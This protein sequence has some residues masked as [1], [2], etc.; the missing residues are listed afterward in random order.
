MKNVLQVLL[1]LGFL[2]LVSC[3]S[4]RESRIVGSEVT[5]SSDGTTMKG[6]LAYDAAKGGKQPGVLVVHE[7]WGL[8]DYARRRARMLAELGYTALAVDMYGAGKQAT[9]PADASKFASEVMQ[10]IETTK[11]RFLAALELLRRQESVD[12]SQVAAIG[13]CFGGGVVLHMAR[14]GVDLKGVASFHGNLATQRPAQPGVVKAR[15]L[16]CNG[17]DDSFVT[18]EQIDQFKK[19]MSAA[20]VD[21]QFISYAGAVHAFTNPEA[22]SLGTKFNLGIAYNKAADEKSWVELQQ[23]FKRVFTQ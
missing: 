21:L 3:S 11:G 2:A 6:Y 17:E 13:Y 12:P 23:F 9:H 19:E 15:V 20:G 16:V 22:D 18:R 14:F 8:N 1:T 10:N 7:W 4:E 5:Y